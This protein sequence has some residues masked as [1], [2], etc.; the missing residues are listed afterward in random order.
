MK[1]KEFSELTKV[2]RRQ[3]R[4]QDH[5]SS[6]SALAEMCKGPNTDGKKLSS[7]LLTLERQAHKITTDQCN[8]DGDQ[9]QQEKELNRIKSII[10]LIQLQLDGPALFVTP[11]IIVI[12]KN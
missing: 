3:L 10:L 2:E 9:Y 8:G 4:L 5:Y 12:L 7:K 6:L 11:T 1:T